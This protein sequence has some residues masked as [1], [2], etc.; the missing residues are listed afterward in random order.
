MGDFCCCVENPVLYLAV[1]D[2]EKLSVTAKHF[3]IFDDDHSSAKA[4]RVGNKLN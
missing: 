2:I 1:P 3:A 4:L